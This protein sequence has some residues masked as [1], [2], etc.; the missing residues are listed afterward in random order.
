MR[1]FDYAEAIVLGQHI[2]KDLMHEPPNVLTPD[3]F[4]KRIQ[5]MTSLGLQVDVMDE[6]QLKAENMHALLSVGQGSSQ[7]E[8]FVKYNPRFSFE[9]LAKLCD[10][11]LCLAVSECALLIVIS[12]R[13]VEGAVHSAV[14][15]ASFC[16]FRCLNKAHIG[17][18][19]R[20]DST[21]LIRA[22]TR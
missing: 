10:N 6:A 2:T 21:D 17:D 8:R 14:F 4:A 3:N 19:A 18:C 16:D 12:N 1:Q 20:I 9:A 22:Q 13:G 11:R 15:E 7:I 5:K